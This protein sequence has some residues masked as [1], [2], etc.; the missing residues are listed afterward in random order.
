MTLTVRSATVSGATT[1]GSALTHAE[2]DENFNH[3]SQSSNHSFTPS[4]SGLSST[5]VQAVIEELATT[6]APTG[7]MVKPGGADTFELNPAD[8]YTDPTVVSSVNFG[9]GDASNP[10]IIG[11]D[12]ALPVGTDLDPGWSTDTGYVA[13]EADF[14][15][16]LG[17]Y[18]CIVNQ[19]A[20]SIWNSN[21]SMISYNSGGHSW[22]GGGSYNWVGPDAQRAVI[23]GARQSAI[24]GGSF[25]LIVGGDDNDITASGSRN[26]VVGGTSHVISGT[27]TDCIIA[28]GN[29]GT[30]S[31]G[32]RN[33]IFAGLNHTVS[34]NESVA[35][36]GSDNTLSGT[37]SAAVGGF[38]NTVSGAEA[39][40]LGGRNSTNAEQAAVVMGEDAIALVPNG[41]HIGR[42]KLVVAGDAQALTAVFAIRTTGNTLTNM[43]A[44]G[45]EFLELDDAA[46]SAGTGKALLVGLSE[47]D[48]TQVMYS[49]EFG[50]MWNGTNG[51]LFKSGTQT[52]V[53]ATP[54]LDMDL[55]SQTNND[56]TAGAAPAIRVSTGSLR[57]AVT[58]IAATNIKW[59]ARVDLVMTKYAN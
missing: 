57:I 6:G 8:N 53:G 49:T 55:V 5:T 43:T 54:S 51:I 17:G 28:G 14:S 7:M 56:F 30:I 42:T 18:D 33:G 26:S 44:T 50:F 36:G 31:G 13:G 1:K 48:G 29:N 58:G 10:C 37:R 39:V 2:L 46:T 4:G 3:L 38:T 45:G 34:V 40:A 24:T 47:A 19:Q 20:S 11:K 12:D 27:T 32:V 52:T 22:I 16:I 35:L 41:F 23:L 59:S 9:A 21:H 15:S 25:Q